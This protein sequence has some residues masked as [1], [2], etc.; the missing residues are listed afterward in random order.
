MIN[1]SVYMNDY[2]V[3]DA[4]SELIDACKMANVY[5]TI[6]IKVAT[7]PSSNDIFVLEFVNISNDKRIEI[8]KSIKDPMLKELSIQK[9]RNFLIDELWRKNKC[10]FY[11]Y[12]GDIYNLLN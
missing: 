11:S 5:F 8:L 7:Y 3:I 4:Y 10:N 9:V 2:K 12:I 1:K 6:H